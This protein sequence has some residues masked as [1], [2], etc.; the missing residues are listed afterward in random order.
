MSTVAQIEDA[1]SRLTMDEAERVRE[2]REPWIEDRREMT[3]E[4]LATIGRGQADLAAG[5][6][7][8]VRAL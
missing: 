8:M 3:P 1:L 5:R 4:F 6:T 2:W 7:R